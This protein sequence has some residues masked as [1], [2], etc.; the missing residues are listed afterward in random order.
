MTTKLTFGVFLLAWML[1][2][3]PT[4]SRE[5]HHVY[6]EEMGTVDVTIKGH[7]FRLWVADDEPERVRGLMF[8]K[9]EQ[10]APLAD[11]TERGMVFVFPGSTR[12]S[13]WM[14]NTVVP[15]DIVYLSAEGE[16]LN[17]YT[18]VPLDDRPYRYLPS[19]PFHVAIEVRGG[20]FHE[21][22]IRPGDHIDLPESLLNRGS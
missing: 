2:A 22:G 4:C 16:V 15:L 21:L 6:D 14:K 12:T 3:M 18:M 1:L 8:Q 19:G 10:M 5:P 11:G 20:V 9:E 17:L 7:K 13:F